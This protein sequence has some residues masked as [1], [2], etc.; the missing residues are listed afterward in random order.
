[1]GVTD[2]L[3]A[4]QGLAGAAV[5]RFGRSRRTFLRSSSTKPISTLMCALITQS[6]VDCILIEL[7]ITESMLM[8]NPAEAAGMLNRLRRIGVKVSIDDFGT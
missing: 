4:N 3:R 6:G 8:H 2:G 5:S 1:M 7:E